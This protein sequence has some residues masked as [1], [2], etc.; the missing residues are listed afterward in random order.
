MGAGEVIEMDP[1]FAAA[2]TG[3]AEAWFRLGVWGGAS[4]AAAIARSEEAELKALEADPN[5]GL[6]YAYLGAVQAVDLR[7]MKDAEAS[8]QTALRLAP[9][10]ALDP[11][12]LLINVNLANITARGIS[13]RRRRRQERSSIWIRPSFEAGSRWVEF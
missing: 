1:E 2:Y 8:F 4:P 11:L 10:S 13:I 6:A 5:Y 12:S 7:R 9:G 3:L